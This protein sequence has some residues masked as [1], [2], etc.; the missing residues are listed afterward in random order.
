MWR[1]MSPGKNLWVGADEHALGQNAM[2]GS[3]LD[4]LG[5]H[6]PVVGTFI[7]REMVRLA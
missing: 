2:F 7:T 3:L 1:L 5:C 6:G 4:A